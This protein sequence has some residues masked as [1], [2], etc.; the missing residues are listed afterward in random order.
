LRIPESKKW[1]DQGAD[2]ASYSPL[3]N[4][5]RRENGDLLF[6]M[7]YARGAKIRLTVA[8]KETAH[9]TVRMGRVY[10]KTRY[11][12]RVAIDACADPR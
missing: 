7:D 5:E 8:E 6:D 2:R 1:P 12:L 10:S 9:P 4:S 3:L 11:C